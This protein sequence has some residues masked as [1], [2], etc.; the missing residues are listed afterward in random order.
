M[1]DR[2]SVII[3]DDFK[4]SLLGLKQML[5]RA[6]IVESVREASNGKELFELVN[7]S[8]PD[9]VLMD[10]QLE[11]ENGIDVTRKLLKQ[12]PDTLVIAITAS[13]DIEHFTDM[14]DAGASGFLLKN[15]TNLELEKAIDEVLAGRL[16]FS[17]EFLSVAKKLLPT[18]KH[19]ISIKLSDREKEVLK[20]ICFGNSNQEIANTLELSAHTIDAHRKNLLSKIGAKNTASM[21]MIA[22]KEGL[23]DFD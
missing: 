15:V 14:M 6:C 21:I 3:V 23:I 22:M 20:L 2:I 19:K 12:F 17:K 7:Q 8:E 18:D 1:A 5:K 10:V 16:Y 4:L 13:K 11:H 9:L